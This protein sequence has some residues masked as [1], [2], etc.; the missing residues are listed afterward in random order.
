MKAPAWLCPLALGALVRVPWLGACPNPA[1]DEGNWALLAL[2]R[3]RGVDAGLSPDAAFVTTA[4][5]RVVSWVF[6]AV[7]PSFAAARAVP[8]AAVLLAIVACVE[9]APRRREG[10]AVA[11]VL[12]LHPWAVLWSRTVSVPY[13]LALCSALV[14]TL[15][16]RASLRTRKGLHV[17]A[18]SQLLG[19]G[20]QLTPLAVIPMVACALSAWRARLPM[21]LA[22]AALSGLVHAVPV[23]AGVVGALHVGRQHA[24][25][26]RT[27]LTEALTTLA[28]MLGGD[29]AGTST[30]AHFAGL[31]PPAL[32]L[33]ALAGAVLAVMVMLHARAQRRW[34]E[35]LYL[36]LATAGVPLMLVP[37]RAW[38]M[39]LIDADRYG[40]ALVAP[41]AL[42][43]G[44]MAS[45]TS[46]AWRGVAR[47]AVLLFAGLTAFA[48]VSLLRG[49]GGDLGLFTAWQG[50][51]YRGWQVARERRAVVDLVRD[52]VLRD[53]RS[54]AVVAYE[55]YAFHP[56]RFSI[57]AASVEGRITHRLGP[58]PERFEGAAYALLWSEGA[59]DARYRPR[60]EGTAQERLRERV[61]AWPGASRVR[62]F[63]T[64]RG[65]ALCELWRLQR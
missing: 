3:A 9:L 46:R 19:V 33:G 30:V 31:S 53:A 37:A 17:V 51:R 49:A 48:G 42:A 15:A 34:E 63:T 60:R 47:G 1:G 13:A 2:Q 10:V 23:A 29:L 20:V 6:R 14:G 25:L 58:L 52:A 39:P 38:A 22:P 28:T 35:V 59:L 12:A 56:L 16:W 55:D 57:A 40:F 5:A 32:T 45:S 54:P 43:V 26:A 8:V 61:R 44:A 24:P 21:R 18:A 11:L 65:D 7:G 27:P 4:F 50:G 62:V 36:A 64:A 41:L